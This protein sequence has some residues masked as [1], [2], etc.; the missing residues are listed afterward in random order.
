MTEA[1]GAVA[2]AV[3]VAIAWLVRD[4]F[5][6]KMRW[7]EQL[8]IEQRPIYMKVL[9]PIMRSLMAKTNPKEAAKGEKLLHSYE[10]RKAQY[11]LLFMGSDD[12][13]V[14]LNE[15]MQFFYKAEDSSS[16]PP[17]KLIELWGGLLLAIRRDLGTGD[18]RLKNI[19]M[20]RASITDI[21]QYANPDEPPS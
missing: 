1:L 9:E 7:Q 11:E 6:S 10:W 8:K 12:V 4:Y 17:K 3:L 18:T 13:L 20:L 19:D 15:M 14:K 21:D 5:Q 2:G 16:I